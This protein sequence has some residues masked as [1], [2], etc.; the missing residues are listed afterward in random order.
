MHITSA[1]IKQLIRSGDVDKL[2]NLVF[3]GQGK[4]LIGGYSADYKVRTFLK[5]VPNIMVKW[6][7]FELI[8]CL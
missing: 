8:Q 2:Q 7:F 4:R 1:Y 6:L 5:S 3:E